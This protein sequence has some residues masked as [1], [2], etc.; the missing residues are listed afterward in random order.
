MNKFDIACKEP[1]GHKAPTFATDAHSSSYS[2]SANTS[3]ALICPAQ[4]YPT[5]L[6]RYMDDQR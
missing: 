3:F 4:A 2:R 5:P 6:F 1:V